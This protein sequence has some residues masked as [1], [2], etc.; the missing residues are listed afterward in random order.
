MY[1]RVV[2][3]WVLMILLVQVENAFGFELF[4]IING[5]FY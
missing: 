5:L 1:S 4:M 3:P 2:G